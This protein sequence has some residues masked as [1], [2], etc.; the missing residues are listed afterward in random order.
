LEEI[1]IPFSIIGAAVTF[2]GIW[3]VSAKRKSKIGLFL[4]PM[5][6]FRLLGVIFI[7]LGIF[8]FSVGMG[9]REIGPY[10]ITIKNS[11]KGD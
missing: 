4:G 8:T 10:K 2:V 6:Y 7:L 3:L 9:L 5:I 11:D 1:S